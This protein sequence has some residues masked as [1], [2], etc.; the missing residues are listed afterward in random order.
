VGVERG[1][2]AMGECKKQCDEPTEAVSSDL[3]LRQ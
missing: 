2:N 3:F 1:G